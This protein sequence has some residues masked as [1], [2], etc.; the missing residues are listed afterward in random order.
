MLACSSRARAR[1]EAECL[2]RHM[3]GANPAAAAPDGGDCHMDGL[4]PARADW[5]HQ[6]H[7]AARDRIVTPVLPSQGNDLAHSPAITL[8]S[9]QQT[10]QLNASTSVQASSLPRPGQSSTDVSQTSVLQNMSGQSTIPHMHPMASQ[11]ATQSGIRQLM[12]QQPDLHQ[13]HLLCQH[14]SAV[15]MQQQQ[16][17]SLQS[18]NLLNGHQ[19]QQMLDQQS[20]SKGNS[21][22]SDKEEFWL[23]ML[24][25][26]DTSS[27]LSA[28]LGTQDKKG[29]APML[30]AVDF[31]EDVPHIHPNPV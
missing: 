4:K 8:V 15:E 25:H 26:S 22:L 28:I 17:L 29:E 11:S 3:G 2:E 6:L 27:L 30:E 16:R 14:N 1:E 23:H 9:Q 20:R 21:I 19:T 7:E 24:E 18:N 31:D 5:R 13:N 10:Q 12:G